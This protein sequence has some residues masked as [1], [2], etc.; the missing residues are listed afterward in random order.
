MC[1]RDLAVLGCVSK[2]AGAAGKGD[3]AISTW[4]DL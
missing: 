1:R 2:M 4:M 3:E